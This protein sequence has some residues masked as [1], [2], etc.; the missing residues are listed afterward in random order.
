MRH[1]G[2]KRPLKK[3]LEHFGETPLRLIDQASIEDA[4]SALFPR[5]TPRQPAI[6]RCS[7]RFRLS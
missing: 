3:L 5:P 7:H 2:D 4:A 1:G 6:G